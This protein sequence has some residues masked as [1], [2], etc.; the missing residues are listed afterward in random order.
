[1]TAE[2]KV[3][4]KDTF[5]L[6][7]NLYVQGKYELCLAEIAKLNEM[8]P[9][10]EN[11][12]EIGDYCEQGRELVKRQKDNDR[13]EH[14]KA[15]LEE[16]I[17]A[18]IDNCRE[19]L[20]QTASVEE[21]SKCLAEAVELNPNHPSILEMVQNAAGREQ[22]AKILAEQRAARD[23]KTAKGM[24]EYQKAKISYQKGLLAKSI[25]EYKRFIASTYP[26]VENAK[27]AARRDVASAEKQLAKKVSLYSDQCKALG[28]KG[29]FKEAYLACDLALKEDPTNEPVLQMRS[30]MLS[31]LRREI[32]AIYEDS[33]LEE[34]MGNVDS[35]KEK[36]KKIK[37]DDLEFD[38]YAKKA[39]VLLKKYGVGM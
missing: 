19:K 4:V 5:N 33:V 7:R 9:H 29:R 27:T 28:D 25:K 2:Q 17:K 21:T 31:N 20:P 35:A 32:K 11:S 15:M 13:R 1:M 14:E 18:V 30:E 23:K 37:N 3:A 16:K 8:L 39:T 26:G 34:S 6:A 22:E 36:W 24:A 12:K 38:D 10:Y